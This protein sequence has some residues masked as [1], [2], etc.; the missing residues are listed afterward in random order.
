MFFF[1]ITKNLNWENL[2]KNLVTFK[3]WDGV[4][5]KHLNIMGAHWKI[6]F[7]GGEGF[8]KKQNIGGNCLKMGAWAVCRFEGGFEKKRGGRVSGGRGVDTPMHTMLRTCHLVINKWFIII[9]FF[10]VDGRSQCW[11]CCFANNMWNYLML[12]LKGWKFT[13]G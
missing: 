6:P 11:H 10:S 7:L 1:V 13:W 5:D 3:R 8:T 9:V 2:T 12:N 4:K